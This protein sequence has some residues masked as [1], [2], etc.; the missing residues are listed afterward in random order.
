MN[1]GEAAWKADTREVREQAHIRAG[2]NAD[3]V[4]GI[5]TITANAAKSREVKRCQQPE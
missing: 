4:P 2:S 3:E 5:A 1:N